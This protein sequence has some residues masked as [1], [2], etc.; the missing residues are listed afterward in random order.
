[1]G[2]ACYTCGKYE[3]MYSE[4]PKSRD[5]LGRTCRR[6][7]D[8]IKTRIKE[9]ECEKWTGYI[10]F[11]VGPSGWLFQN[12]AMNF[13]APKDAEIPSSAERL[14][15]SQEWFCSLHVVNQYVVEIWN[16]VFIV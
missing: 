5:H 13:R 4:I 12:T 3:K 11:K 6:W 14:L 10:W 7:E 16:F 9:I 15:A 1:M 2:G 8:N